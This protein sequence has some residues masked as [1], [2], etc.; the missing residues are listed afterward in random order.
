MDTPEHS[1]V[2]RPDTETRR[3]CSESNTRVS[4]KLAVI[5]S[6]FN[7][8]GFVE[9]AIRSVLDQNRDDCELV[10]IDDGSTDGS[11]EVITSCAVR[12]FRI[13]NQGQLAACVYGL[14][15]TRAPFVLFLDADD[16]LKPGSLAAIVRELDDRVA[17]V[18][19]ALTLIDADDNPIGV[20]S[21]LDTF[22]DRER[23]LDEVLRRGVYKSPPTSGNVFRR[24]V[25]ELLREVDYDKAVDGVIL[26]AA[27][28][29]GD[30][31]SLSQELGCYRI[32]DRNDSRLGQLPT[33]G[34]LDRD[35]NRFV[36]RTEH[37]REVVHR[38]A[39]GRKLVDS[40]KA[41]Y[42]RERKFCLDIMSANRPRFTALPTLL[43]ALAAEPY[44]LKPKL[45]VLAFFVLGSVLPN[46]Q[47]KALL[48]YRSKSGGRSAFGLA[49][50]I[51]RFRAPIES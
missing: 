45:A 12:A 38:L 25:C 9:R 33:T 29:F 46:E 23:L 36:A 18:Q 32:H 11:W 3:D 14:D 50:E 39:P 28:L 21:S 20:F 4:P 47:A 10:V 16:E 24:D 17:K 5:I 1:G 34:T 13:D 31:V 48:A 43:A 42:Y 40:R 37:L 49:K 22:R 35:I 6:C 30:V 27:P 7:Y 2:T 26:F 41:F 8:E 15:R 19:F 51:C 44:P